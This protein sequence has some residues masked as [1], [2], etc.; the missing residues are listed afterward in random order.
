VTRQGEPYEGP[1]ASA[2]DQLSLSIR[3]KATWQHTGLL[4]A[5][6]KTLMHPRGFALALGTGAQ[7]E[8]RGLRVLGEGTEAWSFESDHPEFTRWEAFLTSFRPGGHNHALL[9]AARANPPQAEQET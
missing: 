5:I 4:W 7:D 8:V 6:N 2:A 9:A 3:A 1:V